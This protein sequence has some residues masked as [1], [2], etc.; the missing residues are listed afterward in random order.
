RWTYQGTDYS[1]TSNAV[2][3]DVTQQPVSIATYVATPASTTRLSYS[4][5]ICAGGA[6]TLPGGMTGADGLI[7][8][9]QGATLATGQV[10]MF[11]VN[12]AAHNLNPGAVD[13]LEAVITNVSGDRET[14]TIF[15]TGANTGV[16]V[17]ALPTRASPPAPVPGD[18]KLSV[19]PNERII[20]AV[21][22][23]TASPIVTAQVNVLADPY[24][25][26][27]DSETGTPVD[28]AR[29]SLVDALSGA[30]AT[31]FA[32]DGV[33]PWPS[34]MI[35]GQPV[36]D[37]AGNVY[38]ML[39]GEYRFPLA[40]LGTY[41]LVIEPP[42]PYSAP[43]LATPA[44]LSPLRRPD[45]NAFEIV[46]ASFG[47]SLTLSSPAPVRVDI[48]LD[49]PPVAVSVTKTMSRQTALP[50]DVV[51]YTVTVRNPDP[52]RIKQGVSLVDSASP[53]LRMRKDSIRIDGV[54]PASGAVQFSPD[55]RVM[56]LAL[57][58]IA[59][60]GLRSVTY[61]MSVRA[62][63]P[64]GQAANSVTVKDSRYIT[65]TTGTILRIDRNDIAARMTLIGR[66]TGG[67]CTLDETK[68]F[69][70]AGVR[71]VLED[72]SFAITD[73][74]GRYH[75]EGL[76]PGSHVV[77]ALGNT[78]PKGGQFI[79]CSSSTRSAG[80]ASS[81]FVIGQGGSLV[82]ADFFASVPE[83]RRAAAKPVDDKAMGEA[84]LKAERAAAGADIDWLSYGRGATEFLF[85]AVDHNPRAPVVRV[86]IRHQVT[87]KIRLLVNGKPVDPLAFDGAKQ[88]PGGTFAVSV[89]RGVPL[90]GE[91][92]HL[93]AEVLNED[94]TKKLAELKRDVHF[95]AAPARVELV[96]EKSRLIAD[97]SSRPVL[98][99]RLLD[100]AG[101]PVHAGLSGEF[102]LSAPYESGEALDR[103]Q[104]RALS[105]LGRSAPRWMV[106]ADDGMAYVE[107]APTM[108]S[109]KLHMEFNFSDRDQRRRQELDAWI[110][111]G[112]QPWTLVGLAEG[113]VGAKSVADNMQRAG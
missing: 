20:I 69:G 16:F 7:G 106:K 107:L 46:P 101:R 79:D 82:V 86:A 6:L 24:G 112:D 61:A 63:A 45:G 36:R 109:G 50:G 60:G 14:I 100:R 33:T 32:D 27:F 99:L 41:R 68:R 93:T 103:M 21:G 31:V 92:T 17:G 65:A 72:G 90:E 98:A 13:S 71:V 48:P 40:P 25:L 105:G 97:G 66:I 70:I 38:A 8:A 11:S 18:C 37:G 2:S 87:E 64:A 91:V 76:V 12:A 58:D 67:S 49:H 47:G 94:G 52:A 59:P 102:T 28:G 15:E 42:A 56:T 96:P 35:S 43:S 30:P 4:P 29:I 53:L 78:L 111:P 10:L 22:Q 9:S 1:A 84:A 57:G 74:D 54:A 39:P 44:Q 55:G 89:W 3:F 26:V 85:P 34:T 5:S 73:A 80:S 110:V 95:A 62:D 81:K 77:Q 23:G 108:V 19:V 51:F 83:G 113:S 75:F 88:A 104:E